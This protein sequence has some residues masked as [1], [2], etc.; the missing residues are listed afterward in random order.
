MSLLNKYHDAIFGPID[1]K[2]AD[3]KFDGMI[4]NIVS[5][6]AM[7]RLKR[8]K[9]IGFAANTFV[10]AEHSRFAHALGTMHVMRRLANKYFLYCDSDS[11]LGAVNE[12]FK[13]K[14]NEKSIIQHLLVA[15]LLQDVGE[16]P[17]Q[18]ATKKFFDVKET[19]RNDLSE[20]Y[21]VNFW[22]LNVKQVFTMA[23]IIKD[24]DIQKALFNCEEKIQKDFLAYLI[25]GIIKKKASDE[26][27]SLRNMVDGVID[28]DR[29]DYVVRDSYHTIGVATN[30]DVLI[31]NLIGY[32]SEGPI[33][34]NADPV[35]WFLKRRCELFYSV[36]LSPT[37]R[38][39]K[40]LLMEVLNAI[41]KSEEYETNFFGKSR[42]TRW[43]LDYETF[44]DFDEIELLKMLK[45]L[46]KIV[47][48]HNKVEI[49]LKTLL[50]GYDGFSHRWVRL[51]INEVDD[52]HTYIPDFIYYDTYSDVTNYFAYKSKAIKIKSSEYDVVY[53]DN[54]EIYLE[55][56]QSPLGSFF[57]SIEFTSPLENSISVFYPVNK[58]QESIGT[59]EQLEIG[60]LTRQLYEHDPLIENVFE[61]IEYY[62]F[63]D[64]IIFITYASEDINKALMIA[65]Q[66][67]A[68]KRKYILMYNRGGEI[69]I[70]RDIEHKMI[71]ANV[72][73][74]ILT[75]NYLHKIDNNPECYSAIE[76]EIINNRL[77]TQGQNKL[78][79]IFVTWQDQNFE[80]IK[81][82]FDYRKYG[83]N[84]EPA[85]K[86]IYTNNFARPFQ[87]LLNSL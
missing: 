43:D 4:R 82:N 9:Q 11:I 61:T 39:R 26:I 16:L 65:K 33:F 68:K 1:L 58:Q 74:I 62:N 80:T 51:C 66:L 59:I 37:Y 45:D 8:I 31:E 21:R 17:L 38:L 53:K 50:S 77:S 72:I 5:S 36:Y 48:D 57:K 6:Q 56:I 64:P 28:A 44:I 42:I 3:P 76:R 60:K 13:A 19:L 86:T 27:I 40:I 24:R 85:I 81:A 23:A 67:Y 63:N 69:G 41:R 32:D 70:R 75:I 52:C 78:K 30:I 14:L 83:L 25:T 87:E 18:Q 12:Q 46:A 73:I 34:K 2:D 84:E 22:E 54:S 7:A 71:V 49:A 79:L 10:T 15:C 20:E 55:D 35:F 29:I 47:R